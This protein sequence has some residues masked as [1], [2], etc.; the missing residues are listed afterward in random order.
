MTSDQAGIAALTGAIVDFAVLKGRRLFLLY[1]TQITVLDISEIVKS[2]QKGSSK[3]SVFDT[4][5]QYLDQIPLPS[6]CQ[7]NTLDALS[8]NQDGNATD[9]LVLSHRNQAA[10]TIYYSKVS[11]SVWEDFTLKLDESKVIRDLNFSGHLMSVLL[12]RNEV[13]VV[14]LLT[15]A[16]VFKSQ[17]K[18]ASGKV[19][20]LFYLDPNKIYPR[21]GQRFK[22]VGS[23]SSSG[24]S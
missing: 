1:Q 6:D 15:R 20:R 4:Q 21:R 8:I 3:T 12:D 22:E 23:E 2:S 9:I 10:V 7:Y 13:Q 17:F 11:D 14:D 5:P 16:V 18:D 24:E 19:S